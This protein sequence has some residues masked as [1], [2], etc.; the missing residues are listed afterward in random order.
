MGWQ[1]SKVMRSDVV[2]SRITA[3]LQQNKSLDSFWKKTHSL[4]LPVFPA[5]CFPLLPWIHHN[6]NKSPEWRPTKS[7]VWVQ[8]GPPVLT[9]Y[10]SALMRW[11]YWSLQGNSFITFPAAQEVQRS[12]S[13]TE[14][15]PCSWHGC[16]VSLE[17]ISAG[18]KPVNMDAVSGSPSENIV[19]LNSGSGVSKLGSSCHP[20]Q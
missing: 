3:D 15:H 5:Y 11:F 7:C 9:I 12:G 10:R 20:W 13:A 19:N 14:Q 8:L 1:V 4:L 2:H 6:R 18:Q 16:R 17:S